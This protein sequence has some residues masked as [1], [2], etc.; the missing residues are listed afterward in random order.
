MKTFL[1]LIFF[2]TISFNGARGQ[3]RPNIVYIMA[4]DHCD[5]AIGTYGG[6]L[7]SLDPTPNLDKLAQNGMV[8]ENV[9]CTNSICTPSR[10][11]IMTGQYS[12]VNKAYDLYTGLPREKHYLLKE[13]QQAGYNTAVVGKWHLHTSPQYTDYFAVIAGQGR[14]MNP[15]IHVSEGGKKRKIRF[16]STLEKEVDVIDTEGHS[17]DVLT[18]ISLDWLENKRDK[19][20]PFFLM[21]HFKAPHGMFVYADR[22][23]DYLASVEIPE[24]QNLYNQPS[25]NWGSIGT[26][27]IN[28]SL[29]RVIGSTISPQPDKRNLSR[30]YKSKIQELL[31]KKEL[32]DKELTHYSYQFYLKE[33]LRCVKGIDDNLQRIL[34]YL[35]ENDLTENTIIV[36][37]SDQGMFLGE[38]DFID[39]RWMYDE[40]IRMPLIVHYPK[41]IKPGTHNDWLIN[42]T[43]Y[44]PTLLEIA[45]VQTPNYMQGRSFVGALKGQNEPAEWRKATYY[46]YWMHMA[47]G[48]NNPAH[49]GIRTKKYKLIFFY[50]VDY[51]NIHDKKR[52]SG[53]D[54][55]R[56][57]KST[58]AAWE[59]YDLEKDPNEMINQYANLE[60]APIINEL[61]IELFETREEI[62]DT[63]DEF[64][65]IK[66]VIE[67]N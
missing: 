15:V 36:Y 48:H 50:G 66:G 18:D 64:P 4:D 10:A 35:E 27:G 46:R 13:V 45:G 56:Y 38:H 49:F 39:K 61:K 22:Y 8:F 1:T 17:S 55:N 41:M 20:K 43:D 2:I 65:R 25:E 29:V 11:T 44:A 37:T 7:A 57:W 23:K 28:D 6:R 60:Y 33:Y 5:R 31:G 67:K 14:Y 32:T 62:G 59:F 16:D 53:K 3:E 12:H 24:P 26:R 42:N 54:G 9:Y 19:S 30:Y 51:T 63:D 47:H 21:H 58:P 40:S 34:D 52:V